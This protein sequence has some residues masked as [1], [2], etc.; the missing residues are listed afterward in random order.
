MRRRKLYTFGIVLLMAGVLLG[1]QISSA[2]SSDNTFQSLLKLENAFRLI[3][4]SY[5]EDVDSAELVE[6]AIEGMLDGLD[7]HSVY[8]DAETMRKVNEDFNASFEGIGISF[9]FIQG[10]EG[11]DRDTIAVLNVIPGGPSEEVGLSSGDRIVAIDDT[12]A[13]GFN[14]LQV[15]QYLKG[16]RGTKVKVTV[17]RPG[18]GRPMDFTITRDKIQLYTKDAH[19][20]IDDETGFIRINRFARTTYDEFMEGLQDLKAQGMKRLVLDLRDN[21]GG[22]MDMAIRISDEFLGEGQMIVS[23]R[24]RHPEFNQSFYA[25]AGGAFEDDPV[26]VLVN[27]RSASASEIVAGAL[28]DHDRA[29]IIGERT[30]GKGLVQKQYTLSDNSVLRMTISRY[31]TPAGRLIQTPYE[32]GGREDYYEEKREQRRID[33]V[34]PREILEDVPDSLKFETDGGR[35]VFGGGGILPDYIV[36]P[37][38]SSAFVRAVSGLGSEFVRNWLDVHGGQVHGNWDGRRQAFIDAYEVTDDMFEAFLSF[39]EAR[40]SIEI[41]EGPKPEVVEGDED[42]PVYVT[43]AEVADDEAWLRTWL[44]TRLAR[45]LFD[46]SAQYPIYNQVDRVFLE[47]MQLWEPA[48]ALALSYDAR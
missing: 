4:E 28:Q 25:R 14:S 11:S 46:T 18:L 29:L 33:A 3:Q 48:E 15:Q 2:V 35:I 12:T 36:Q 47:A 26:I 37:D 39:A 21:P 41:V 5:V 1:M 19:Y 34:T 30:F 20:M 38:S 9:E 45:R 42:A 13:I 40:S 32:N 8:I 7:P 16:P 43:R 10:P 24:S 22:Y 6:S 31:Y 44:K 17:K 27:S 23:Q